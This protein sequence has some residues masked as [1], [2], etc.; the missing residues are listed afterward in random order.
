[1]RKKSSEIKW[2]RAKP[3]FDKMENWRA[4]SCILQFY[5]YW[6]WPFGKM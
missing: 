5:R 3:R 2:C 4:E 6:R 1:V